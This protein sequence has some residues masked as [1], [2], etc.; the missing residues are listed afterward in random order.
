MKRDLAQDFG[1]RVVKQFPASELAKWKAK[2]PDVL[3][4]WIK[5]MEKRGQGDMAK[6]V[7]KRWRELTAN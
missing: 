6:R 2:A 3:A 4:S 1:P 5:D 7:A